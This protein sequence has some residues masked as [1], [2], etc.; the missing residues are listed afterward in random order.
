MMLYHIW[1]LLKDAKP[2]IEASQTL[3]RSSKFENLGKR[4]GRMSSHGCRVKKNRSQ[5]I[6]DKLYVIR[7][8][9]R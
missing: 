6:V 1:K 4:E 8:N 5:F 7:D 3:I 2:Y 9:L